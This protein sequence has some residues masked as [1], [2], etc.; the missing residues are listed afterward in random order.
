MRTYQT[1]KRTVITAF[2]VLCVGI[3]ANAQIG[4][5]INKAKQ[6]VKNKVEN[7]VSGNS[8]SSSTSNVKNKVKEKATA[9]AASKVAV[10]KFGEAPE[11][12][13]IMALKPVSSQGDPTAKAIKNFVWEMRT[14]TLDEAK[15]LAAQLTARAKWNRSVC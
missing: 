15:K 9:A 1:T 11:L 13:E 6:K 5:I 2:V 7:V 4:K 3:C 12:P 10:T 14:M 8:G